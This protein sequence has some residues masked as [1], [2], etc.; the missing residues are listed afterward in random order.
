MEELTN[1]YDELKKSVQA[2]AKKLA[3]N[4]IENNPNEYNPREVDYG[5]YHNGTGFSCYGKD[6]E[7]DENKA[8][9]HAIDKIA[10]DIAN[11]GDDYEFY[12]KFF[13]ENNKLTE[14]LAKLIKTMK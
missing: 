1:F 12:Y 3:D 4:L 11:S 14:A 9:E 10:T 5:Y 13:V 2:E 6:T 8:F 7:Y